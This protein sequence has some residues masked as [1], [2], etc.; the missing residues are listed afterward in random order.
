[1]KVTNEEKDIGVIITNNFKPS[2]QCAAAAKN[3]KCTEPNYTGISLP[4]PPCLC[5]TV[6]TVHRPHLKFA[7]PARSPWTEGDNKTHEKVQQRAIKMVSGLHFNEY[8]ER[9]RELRIKT[10]EERQH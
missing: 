10:L 6:L 5:K 4:G 1:M 8:E 7:T 2:T 9:L 3:V